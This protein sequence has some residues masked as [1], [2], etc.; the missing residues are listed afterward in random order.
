MWRVSKQG[1]SG[2]HNANAFLGSLDDVGGRIVSETPHSSIPGIKNIEYEI[3]KKELMGNQWYHQSTEFQ[4]IQKQ[5]T[6][7]TL[8]VINKYMSGDRKQCKMGL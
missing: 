7:L 3:P 8:L 6:T 5:S 4:I 1:I 2:G